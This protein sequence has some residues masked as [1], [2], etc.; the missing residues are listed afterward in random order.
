MGGVRLSRDVICEANNL[1]CETDQQVE[2]W[3]Y[4]RFPAGKRRLVLPRL[5][6]PYG[7]GSIS[8]KLVES[9]AETHA[10][11]GGQK[12]DWY[13][14][15]GNTS[16]SRDQFSK[17]SIKYDNSSSNTRFSTGSFG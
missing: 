17:C 2:C 10:Y 11:I 14:D 16:R 7:N 15:D 9:F 4:R 5:T 8:D 1:H 6:I 3:G 12:W 13:A